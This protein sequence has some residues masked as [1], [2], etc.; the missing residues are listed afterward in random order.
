MPRPF[1]LLEAIEAAIHDVLDDGGLNAQQLTFVQHIQKTNTELSRAVVAIPQTEHALRRILPAFGDS[2]LQQEVALFGYARLLL[3]NPDS[4]GGAILSEYQQD[5][6]QQIY[7]HGQALHQL[8]Q[9][10]VEDARTERIKQHRAQAKKLDLETF[11]TDETPILHYVLRNHPVELSITTSSITVFAVPYHLAALIQHIVTIISHDLIESGHIKILTKDN[12]DSGI[13]DIFCTGIQLNAE[14][15]DALFQKNGHY[16]YP[17]RLEQSGGKLRFE[18][19]IG[20]GA[21]IQ[22]HLSKFKPHSNQNLTI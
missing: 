21:S 6:M 9:K 22:I 10:I 12:A 20:R 1:E 2:F 11:F 14:E 8:S 13:I 4:F 5:K 15:I 16:F 17:Q 18:R 3:E 19:Q 7:Q